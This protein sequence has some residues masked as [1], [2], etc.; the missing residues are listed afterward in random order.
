MTA[1]IDACAFPYDQDSWHCY[2]DRLI[3]HAEEYFARFGALFAAQFDLDHDDYRRALAS[4]GPAAASALL[5]D[6]AKPF[7]LGEYLAA[8]E[9][10]GVVAEIALGAPGAPNDHVIDLARQAPGRIHAWAGLSLTDADA[11]L[12][13]LQRCL[14][15]GATGVFI[16]PVLD[17]IDITCDR[18]ADV[19][20][21]AA[22]RR[23][24]LYLH[25][26]QHFV[27]AQPLDVTTWRPSTPSPAATPTCA[28]SAPTRAG[29]GSW[30]PCSSPP[31][32]T[33][34]TSTSPDTTPAEW[35]PPASAGNPSPP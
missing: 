17:G 30:R 18:F 10:E 32:T 12:A 28:S 29:P 26:G 1:I 14:Q 25:T 11:A 7:D 2:F 4:G 19:L 5:L 23:L 33:T 13:E 31:A 16:A 21:L 34:S 22:D 3:G 35:P 8:R 6:H 27:R 24:P 15:A 20:G 9:R